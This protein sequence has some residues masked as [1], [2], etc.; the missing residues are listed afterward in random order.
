MV[1][2]ALLTL[3]GCVERRLTIRTDPPSALV[4]LDGRE[5][6][7]TPISIPFTHYG[8]RRVQI[9]KDGFETMTIDQPIYTPWYQY[10]PLDFIT[11]VLVP[12][13]IRDEREYEYVMEPAK[14]VSVDELQARARSVREQALAPPDDATRRPGFFERRRRSDTERDAPRRGE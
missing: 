7:F 9:V 12:W 2:L 11:E 10:F 1:A 14:G 8:N 4:R 6:G 13:N 3:A 5:I